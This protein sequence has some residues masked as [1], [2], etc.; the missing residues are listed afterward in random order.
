MMQL[1]KTD[2][3]IQQSQKA[4]IRVGGYIVFGADPVGVGVRFNFR[5]ISSELV[6][7]F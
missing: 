6:D 1:L 5:A 7:G 2:D 4:H 3:S